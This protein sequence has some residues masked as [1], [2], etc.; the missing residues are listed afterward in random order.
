M[1]QK[2]KKIKILDNVFF[3]IFVSSWSYNCLWMKVASIKMKFY[4]F[5]FI[6]KLL[7]ARN[8]YKLYDETKKKKKKNPR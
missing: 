1:K 7:F 6:M 8:E 4:R 5:V 2:I 3:Y